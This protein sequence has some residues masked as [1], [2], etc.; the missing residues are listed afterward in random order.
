[1]PDQPDRQTLIEQLRR[2]PI[3]TGLDEPMLSQLAQSAIW[4]EYAAGEAVF[5][6]NEP[7]AGLYY[8]T[9]GWIKITKSSPDGREIV[10]RMV[11]PGE[12]FND[13]G[14]FST[15]PNPSGARALEPVGLWLIKQE[16]IRWLIRERPDLAFNVI[17]SLV[18]RV[19][20][21]INLVAD[22]SMRS[23]S[24]RLARLLLDEAINDVL[25]RAR[26]NTQAELA[27]RLGTVADVLQRTLQTL[28]KAGAI[29]VTRQEIR[30]RD[31]SQLE[32][33]AS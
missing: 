28:E 33:L 10:L 11:S 27:A 6:E 32:K 30:L 19:T 21:L 5:L 22:L 15:H 16:T 12:T 24:N 31:R 17:D 9:S 18:E 13:F 1:M 14:A 2:L 8:L 29:S 4:R 23:V 25:P 3:L 20:N 7:S 26:W